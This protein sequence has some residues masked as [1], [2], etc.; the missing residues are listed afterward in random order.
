MTHLTTNFTLEEFLRTSHT[1]CVQNQNE[2]YKEYLPNLYITAG[3]LQLIRDY[4]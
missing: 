1:D 2:E 3:I 4:Y